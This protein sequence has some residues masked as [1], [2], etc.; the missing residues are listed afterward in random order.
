VLTR[1]LLVRV[2]PQSLLSLCS[3]CVHPV[4]M[5]CIHANGVSNEATR[6]CSSSAHPVFPTF[7]L[8]SSSVHPLLILCSSPSSAH[9]V[10][11]LR[12]EMAIVMMHLF[13]VDHVSIFCSS[14]VHPLFILCSSCLM[15]YWDRNEAEIGVMH[16][17][18]VDPLRVDPLFIPCVHKHGGVD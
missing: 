6:S 4:L 16:L 3:P 11:I 14:S 8:C 5:L 12:N 13:C 9:P 15:L 10:F 7:V 1:P 2:R 18:C 17:P